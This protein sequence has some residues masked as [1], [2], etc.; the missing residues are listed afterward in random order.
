[1]FTVFYCHGSNCVLQSNILIDDLE[2]PRISNL[3]IEAVNDL[4]AA[5]LY[6]S[7]TKGNESVRWQAPELLLPDTYGGNGRHSTA[8]DVY[9]FGMTCLEVRIDLVEQ[10]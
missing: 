8:S 7:T 4:Q 9:A 6:K 3:C 5:E 10:I 1:M 2:Q